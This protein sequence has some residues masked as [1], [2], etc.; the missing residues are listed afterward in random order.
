MTGKWGGCWCAGGE[1]EF[2]VACSREE[3]AAL[4]G[5]VESQAGQ[6]REGEVF[7]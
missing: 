7:L 3:S 6:E 5:P 2:G 4:Q 1:A